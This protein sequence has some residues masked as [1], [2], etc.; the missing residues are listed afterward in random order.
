MLSVRSCTP[1][2]LTILAGLVLGARPVAAQDREQ[3]RLEAGDLVRVTNA[4]DAWLIGHL[5]EVGPA[6]LLIAP[7][8]TPD[9]V[10]RVDLADVTGIARRERRGN[11][12]LGAGI[13]SGI[14]ILAAIPFA[15][16]AGDCPHDKSLDACIGDTFLTILGA[17]I[18]GALGG[19][20][21]GALIGAPIKTDQWVALDAPVV[22]AAVGTIPGDP[23]RWF[24]G[25][26]IRP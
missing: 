12:K 25:L 21:I 26:K 9:E 19:A 1:W 6:W 11:A 14:G 13:G 2:S 7:E 22:A 18:L 4:D 8:S 15:A 5:R 3:A 17:P 23:S 24:V 20:A 16:S 10:I